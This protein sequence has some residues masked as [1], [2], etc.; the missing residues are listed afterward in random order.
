MDTNEPCKNHLVAFVPNPNPKFCHSLMT[1]CTCKAISQP[2]V[3]LSDLRKGHIYLDIWQ[4]K[5]DRHVFYL[6]D[7]LF[8]SY[9]LQWFLFPVLGQYAKPIFTDSGKYCQYFFSCAK[10]QPLW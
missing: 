10:L 5:V 1:A 9:L 8:L 7:N 3:L 6:S 4:L 2:S